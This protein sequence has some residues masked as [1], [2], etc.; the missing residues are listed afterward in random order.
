MNLS[1]LV[2]HN[3]IVHQKPGSTIPQSSSNDKTNSNTNLDNKTVSPSNE[4]SK[5]EVIFQE[6]KVKSEIFLAS[7]LPN[8]T[9]ISTLGETIFVLLLIVPIL[10][11]RIKKKL[12]S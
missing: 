11:L 3:G 6:T 12:H 8:Q 1:S 10:L 5:N 7:N 9:L 4:V 2:A